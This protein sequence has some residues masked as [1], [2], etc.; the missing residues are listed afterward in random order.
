MRWRK[1]KSL[2]RQLAAFVGSSRILANSHLYGSVSMRDS[3]DGQNR[4]VWLL[5]LVLMGLS[6]QCG[7]TYEPLQPRIVTEPMNR[8]E[9]FYKIDQMLHER[10]VVPIDVFLEVLDVS[11]ATF[12]RNMEYH[13]FV[14]IP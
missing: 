7:A 10:H 5:F 13:I 8:T 2:A 12:K 14:R 6:H 1:R 3:L 9:R 4:P 11:R